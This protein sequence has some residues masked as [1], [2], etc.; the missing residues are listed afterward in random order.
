MAHRKHHSR[1]SRR[2]NKNRSSKKN[3]INKTVSKGVSLVSSTSSKYMP[4]VKSGLSNVGS[5]VIKT[6]QTTVPYLQKLTRKAF[7]AV[8]L[9]PVKSRR[10][11]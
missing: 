11:R 7:G 6:G 9:K 8:G 5:K 2:S 3:I 1:K 4:K 10:R